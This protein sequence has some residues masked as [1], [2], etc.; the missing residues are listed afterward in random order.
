MSVKQVQNCVD[1]KNKR[2]NVNLR[3]K[4]MTGKD[5]MSLLKTQYDAVT[6]CGRTY[7]DKL[8]K[9]MTILQLAIKKN[10]IDLIT[11]DFQN[12]CNNLKLVKNKK[13]HETCFQRNTKIN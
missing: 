9:G 8:P 5:H 2:K 7:R 11:R 4:A 12:Y 13:S 3:K 10:V 1:F 6:K